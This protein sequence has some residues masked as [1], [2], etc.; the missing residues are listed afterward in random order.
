M[1]GIQSGILLHIV[2]GLLLQGPITT[3]PQ[4][5]WPAQNGEFLVN[6]MLSIFDH[7]KPEKEFMHK[8]LPPIG[9]V[10]NISQMEALPMVATRV[11]VETISFY[12]ENCQILGHLQEQCN[13]LYVLL[14]QL[15]EMLA[16]YKTNTADY[17]EAMEAISKKFRKLR[18]R[19]Q[20]RGHT[21]HAQDLIWLTVIEDLRSVAAHLSVIGTQSLMNGT[22]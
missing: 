20:K 11:F 22:F 10:F 19:A 6:Q 1:S 18:R 4:C 9:S 12:T 2:L 13:K 15:G 21:A 17:K 14:H 7:L 5:P 3:S 16:Q 8:K